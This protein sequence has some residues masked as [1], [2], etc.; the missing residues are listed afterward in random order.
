MAPSSTII[1]TGATGNLGS[2]IAKTVAS[3]YP[4]RFYLL[5]TCRSVE[6]AAAVS[7]QN[8]LRSKDAAFSL[9]RLD[10]SDLGAVKKFTEEVKQKINSGA[11]PSLVGGGIVNS[12]A[13]MNFTKDSKTSAG[14]D[15]M[16]TINALAPALLARGLLEVMYGRDGGGGATVVSVGSQ[17]HELGRVDYFQQSKGSGEKGAEGVG[18]GERLGFMEAMKRYGSSKLLLIMMSYAFQRHLYA[19]SS[20][21]ITLKLE[22]CTES[23]NG[24]RIQRPRPSL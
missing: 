22:I 4:G 11:M 2:T 13:F 14:L 10:L 16:Y 15:D 20:F 18:K 3:L 1:I 21:P 9:E 17:A 8:A 23:G 5:L 24:R 7:L 12:A 6:N 19:V